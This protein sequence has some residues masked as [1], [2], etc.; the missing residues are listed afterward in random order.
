[1]A[2]SG[3][4][5]QAHTPLG[6]LL[7]AGPAGG[8]PQPPTHS[9]QFVLVIAQAHGQEGAAPELQ[10]PAVQLLGHEVEPTEKTELVLALALHRREGHAQRAARGGGSQGSQGSFAGSL[11]DR[12]ASHLPCGCARQWE[13]TSMFYTKQSP[14]TLPR[15]G[16]QGHPLSVLFTWTTPGL[17]LRLY[18]DPLPQLRAAE[19][20]VLML[21]EP[22]AMC[23]LEHKALSTSLGNSAKRQHSAQ[24][25]D[26]P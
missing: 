10:Q 17:R 5:K 26:V 2:A 24:D 23:T 22:H 15:R 16:S 25:I 8:H 14:Q 20:G 19:L 6:T 3:L 13:Q 21:Q 1:M 18:R 12:R 7:P 4:Q 11:T 9:P